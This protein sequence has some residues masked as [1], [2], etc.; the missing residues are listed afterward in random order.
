MQ[1]KGRIAERALVRT[2]RFDYQLPP[3]LIAQ[4]PVEPRDASRLMVVERST[5][6]LAHRH[7]YELVDILQ[8]GDVLVANDSRVMPARLFA[9]KATGGR[10]EILLLVRKGERTWETL[11]RGHRVR[12]G[13]TL[14]L[15]AR[16]EITADVL[17]ITPSGGRILRFSEPLDRYLP[18]VGEIPLPPYIHKP[19]K[20]PERY[21]TVYARKEGSAAA[22][23]A[24]LHFTPRLIERLKAKGIEF[25]FVTLH[26]G[27]DTFRPITE[28]HVE[29]HKIHS[30]W[31]ELT[32]P[33]A[34]AL[35]RAKAE[36]RRIIAI[37]TTAMRVL[38]T[39]THP[40]AVQGEDAR[41][42]WPEDTPPE[43]PRSPFVPFRGWTTL[44]ITP[45][46]AFRGVDALITNFH[47]PRST[48]LVLVAAFMGE[49]LMWR[50]YNEAIRRRYRF[51]SFGD[52][53]LIL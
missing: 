15:E 40:E 16:P 4:E 7:F 23:T 43:V 38:E 37:G 21:Q 29:E 30:E 33:V 42:G 18:Q 25:H 27:L 52:A 31:A 48:L 20:N 50:A 9:R 49:D 10:V 44:Y 17:A 13:I 6:R 32:A 1:D 47:L 46:F 14:R 45:G 36:G 5:G 2:E 51:Y 26:V 53:M 41:V 11:V 35:N 24:G 34:A 39:A 19:L 12:P 28:E 8:P 3:E 22:P